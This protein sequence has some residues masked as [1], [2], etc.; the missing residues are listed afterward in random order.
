METHLVKF[1]LTLL[2]GLLMFLSAFILRLSYTDSLELG[3]N[4]IHPGESR[5]CEVRLTSVP[6]GSRPW[7]DAFWEMDLLSSC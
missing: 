5:S 1:K 3:Q 4:G 6:V 7:E 2:Q